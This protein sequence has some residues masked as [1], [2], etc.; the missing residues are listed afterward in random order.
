MCIV[1]RNGVD[2]LVVTVACRGEAINIP[3]AVASRN[4]DLD[5]HLGHFFDNGMAIRLTS[6][7]AEIDN[8][9]VEQIVL[10]DHVPG[11]LEGL[12]N[13]AAASPAPVREGLE[14]DDLGSWGNTS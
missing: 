2:I 9:F 8:S 3:T 12:V 13:V 5:T 4:S 14:G 1:R 6:T 10:N 11:I 7:K